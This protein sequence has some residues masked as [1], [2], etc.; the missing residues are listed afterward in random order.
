MPKV[1]W[2]E[3]GRNL[4]RVGVFRFLGVRYI[5]TEITW[6]EHINRVVI[7]GNKILN[8]MCCL[9]GMVWGE[10]WIEWC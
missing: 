3:S 4:K 1:V 9:L 10:G 5:D 7:K 8:V 2:E 6:A